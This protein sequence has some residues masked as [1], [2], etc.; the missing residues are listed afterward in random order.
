MTVKFGGGS[1]MMW[2]CFSWFGLGPLVPVVESMNS[3]MYV[4]ILDNAVL[5]TLWPIS[6]QAG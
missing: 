3:E 1:I 5:S 4:D 6:L 2:G